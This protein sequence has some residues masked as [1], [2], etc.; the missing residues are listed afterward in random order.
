MTLTTGTIYVLRDG[1]GACRYVGSTEHPLPLR[2]ARHRSAAVS[3]PLSCPLYREG[4]DLR[5]WEIAALLEVSYDAAVCPTA[6]L[7]AEQSAI[8]GL[9]ADGAQLLNKARAIDPNVARRQYMAAWRSAHPEYM[10]R[11]G[12]VHRDRWRQRMH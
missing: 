7:D 12:R 10:S 8:D 1:D 9:R 4:G 2:L 5:D 6:L 11:A 3:D